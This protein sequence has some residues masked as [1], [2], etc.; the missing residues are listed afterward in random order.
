[1]SMKAIAT[2]VM[3]G[4]VTVVLFAVPGF[5]GQQPQSHPHPAPAT[6]KAAAKPAPAMEAKCQ[7]MMADHKT[8]M[9]DMKAADGRLD[10]LVAT[11]N[12]ATGT[13]KGTATAAVVAEMATGGRA[14]RDRMMK[15]DQD[16]MAHMM[17]HMQA[18]KDSMA[19][20]PMM[21]PMAAMKH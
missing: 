9:A 8:M 3:F 15:M 11:M 7:A 16:M 12:N 14:T 21:K 1:M 2:T 18:G 4:C 13:D 20:C 5:A 10:A 17:E 19:S 6:A